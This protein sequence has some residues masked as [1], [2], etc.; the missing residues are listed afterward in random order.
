MSE[1]LKG[2]PPTEFPK[3][4]DGGL[5]NVIRYN[6]KPYRKAGRAARLNNISEFLDPPVGR[7]ISPSYPVS[8]EAPSAGARTYIL[9]R[10]RFQN[11]AGA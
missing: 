11:K 7:E 5:L 1:H 2:H 6:T 10:P 4:G 3:T 9:T 8:T